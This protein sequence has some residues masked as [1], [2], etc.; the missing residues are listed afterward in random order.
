M[1]STRVIFIC[2][3]L[4]MLLFGS[5][6]ITLGSVAAP[7]REKFQ[8]D[9]I[10]SGTL[11]SILPIGILVG[12]LLFGPF[13]DR[14][15]SK[16]ILLLS[17]LFIFAGFQG[18]A[19]ASSLNI[20][21]ICIFLFGLGG[22]MINGATNAVVADISATNKGANLS[23]LGVFFA[24]GALGMPFVLGA[25]QTKFSFEVIV[26]VIGYIPVAVAILYLFTR[27]PSPK[28][29]KGI[30][31]AKGLGLLKEGVLISIGFFLFCLSSFE[32]IIN[33]WT[34]TYL[35]QQLSIASSQALYAL[36]LY[37]VGMAAMRLLLGSVFRNVS[38]RMILG[39]SFVF[40][41]SGCLL[42]HTPENYP[43][44]VTGLI[45]IGI[46]LAAG[47]PVMLG[48]VGNLYADVSGTAF[49][50]VLTIALIGN[51][52]INFTMGVIAERHGVQHLTTVAFSLL[53]AMYFLTLIILKKTKI[54]HV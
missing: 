11:F 3:C 24:V 40:L 4:G 33:N 29:A 7:L 52:L 28:Q 38:A 34:T 6:L 8:L 35:L 14:Y 9:A 53:A 37:V 46:G 13:S 25:L 20:L 50:I 36:S 54:K 21:K 30:P 27:F 39:F 16:V 15:G 51:M 22:G 17:C 18:I 12:S 47:F 32:A 44:A 23:L 26:S 31:L 43:V 42:L 41:L 49:S 5:S 2:A 48:F 10:T 19:Y 1:R 45:C